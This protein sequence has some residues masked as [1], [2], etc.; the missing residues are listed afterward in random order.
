LIRGI[1]S[2]AGAVGSAVG[3]LLRRA[4]EAGRR[5]IQAHSP[6]RLFMQ[7]GDYT[8][9]GYIAG[10][11]RQ[12]SAIRA[13]ARE[14]ALAMVPDVPAVRAPQLRLAGMRTPGASHIL[15]T[16]VES[17]SR[18]VVE[19]RGPG[20]ERFS[21]DEMASLLADRLRARRRRG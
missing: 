1:L 11:K 9:L 20:A 3:N 18:I 15:T 19:F 13:A 14:M 6:S 21:P 4:Y 17:V 16:R 5:A 2:M 8:G 7:L 12:L 10:V